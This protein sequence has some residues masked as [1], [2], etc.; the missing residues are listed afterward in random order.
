MIPLSQDGG[1]RGFQPG[2]KKPTSD[3]ACN[4]GDLGSIPG[5]GRSRGEENGYPLRYSGL[6]NSMDR[7]SWRAVIHGV[8][9]EL[10]MTE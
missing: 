7:G 2:G 9:K 6:Q 4:P 5:S 8:T 1:G 3:T 10:D